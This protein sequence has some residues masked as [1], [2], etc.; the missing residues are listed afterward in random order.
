MAL[1]HKNRFLVQ[2]LLVLV[3]SFAEI[4]YGYTFFMST[5]PSATTI[6]SDYDASTRPRSTIA[7]PTTPTTSL[8]PALTTVPAMIT[9]IA[10]TTPSTPKPS[11]M[12]VRESLVI[13]ATNSEREAQELYDKALKQYGSYGATAR[14]VCAMWEMRGCHCYGTVEELMLTCRSVGFKEVPSDLPLDIAKL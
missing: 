9:S 1:W 14:K 4:K 5:I 13:P 11:R 7:T 8:Q 3:L 12:A 6:A 2:G 10:Y